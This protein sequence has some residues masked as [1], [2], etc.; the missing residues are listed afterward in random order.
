M[1]KFNFYSSTRMVGSQVHEVVEVPDDE[2]K[3]MTLRLLKDKKG[4]QK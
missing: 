1:A 4:G 3:G 2:L